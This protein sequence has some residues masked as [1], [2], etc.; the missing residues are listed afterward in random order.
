MGNVNVSVDVEGVSDVTAI[1]RLSDFGCYPQVTEVVRAVTIRE[2]GGEST[3]VWEV[4]FRKGILKWVERD[5]FDRDNREIS[6]VQ[7]E[8]DLKSFSGRWRVVPWP[9]GGVTVTFEA[10]FDLGMPS[11]ATIVEPIAERTLIDNTR[12]IIE[13]LVRPSNELAGRQVRKTTA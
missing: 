6:F 3:S 9:S 7:T 2:S 11:I 10:K 1:D 5:T 4:N 13:Q 8:G 12:T